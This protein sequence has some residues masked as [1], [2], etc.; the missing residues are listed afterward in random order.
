MYSSYVIHLSLLSYLIAQKH[1]ITFFPNTLHFLTHFL[2][3]FKSGSWSKNRIFCSEYEKPSHSLLFLSLGNWGKEASVWKGVEDGRKPQGGPG[4][5]L[6]F[7]HPAWVPEAWEWR[8]LCAVLADL[9]GHPSVLLQGVAW[10]AAVCITGL[11][12]QNSHSPFP[13]PPHSKSQ[14]FTPKDISGNWPWC[15]APAA[16]PHHLEYM[17]GPAPSEGGA[18]HACQ[19]SPQSHLPR[20]PQTPAGPGSA[21]PVHHPRA[22][23]PTPAALNPDFCIP[24]QTGQ[25]SRL[26]EQVELREDEV[27]SVFFSQHVNSQTSVCK[28]SPLEFVENANFLAYSPSIS[29]SRYRMDT[30]SVPRS[31]HHE[32]GWLGISLFYNECPSFIKTR[33]Y[34]VKGSTYGNPW[35]NP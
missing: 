1:Q 25:C 19:V 14:L 12:G 29:A 11:G 18:L 35:E 10:Q 13:P 17:A 6:V 21:L 30:G 26:C 20:C 23:V 16:I 15:P 3:C 34:Q 31:W 4:L 22:P 8:S 32:K 28:H 33:L 24:T 27:F 7:A 2:V 5:V 9:T